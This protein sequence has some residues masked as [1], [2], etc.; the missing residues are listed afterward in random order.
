MCCIFKHQC[1]REIVNVFGSTR[2]MHEFSKGPQLIDALNLGLKEI[3]DCFDVVT[4]LFLD[5]FNAFRINM[6]K[7]VL[8]LIKRFFCLDEGGDGDILALRELQA[9]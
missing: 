9:S 2:K 3:F 5:G 1:V 4:N 8:Y 6:R 7:R